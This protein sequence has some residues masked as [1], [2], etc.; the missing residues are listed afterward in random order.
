M[1]FEREWNKWACGTTVWLAT[2]IADFGRSKFAFFRDFASTLFTRQP[3]SSHQV[4]HLFKLTCVGAGNLALQN[5]HRRSGRY[6]VKLMKTRRRNIGSSN[7]RLL[8]PVSLA[9]V[10]VLSMAAPPSTLLLVCLLP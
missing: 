5:G 9:S 4:P 3:W 10:V 6:S 2:R 8:R 7:R 1:L